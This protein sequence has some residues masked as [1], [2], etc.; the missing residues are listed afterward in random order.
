VLGSLWISHETCI[1]DS[2]VL[3]HLGFQSTVLSGPLTDWRAWVGFCTLSPQQ[4]IEYQLW[5][6]IVFVEGVFYEY[7]MK[8]ILRTAKFLPSWGFNQ[9]HCLGLYLTEVPG[10]VSAPQAHSRVSNINLD[11]W[12]FF[13]AGGLYEYP[14]NNIL[15][16]AKFLPTWGI[17][18]RYCP[19][20]KPTEV[21]GWV[22]A[23]QVHSRVSNI[24]FDIWIIFSGGGLYKYPMENVLR[25][26]KFLSTWDLNQ[27]YW[28]GL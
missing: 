11:I 6:L 10:W 12:I 16:T 7:P 3:A 8:N 1:K 24:N 26:A 27:R 13:C 15:R 28:S 2:T 23:P 18:Q 5:Y 17:N 14:M 25:R 4:S 19:G 21:P 9:R 20:F 22:S